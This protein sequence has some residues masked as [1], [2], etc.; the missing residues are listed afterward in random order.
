M[1]R[2]PEVLDARLGLVVQVP[3][4]DR[5]E[6]PIAEARAE[7]ERVGLLLAD[8]ELRLTQTLDAAWQRYRIALGQ[9]SAYES[10]IL[11]EA[12]AALRVAEAAYRFG[13][14]GILDFLDAQR[15][16]RTLRSELNAT[17]YDLRAALVELERL[18]A[19]SE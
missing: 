16:L 12:E 8:T 11:R 10:G 13:E 2:T 7:A 1:E 9:V 18:R 17:R 5:R 3:V 15:T 6:G 14:R 4:F 19:E